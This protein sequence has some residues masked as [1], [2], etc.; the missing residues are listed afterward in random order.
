M[1]IVM[2]LAA[3]YAGVVAARAALHSL[4]QLP[5]SNEDFVHY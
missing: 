2:S 4:R 1:L 3:L 5:R